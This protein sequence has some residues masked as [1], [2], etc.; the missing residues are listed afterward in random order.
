V[1]KNSGRRSTLFLRQEDIREA[2]RAIGVEPAALQA[3]A[4]VEASGTGFLPDGR[5]KILFEGHIMW[6]EL[7][8]RGLDPERFS[9]LYPSI[10]YRRWTRKHY[11]G[12][13]GEYARYEA[14]LKI[15][16]EAAIASTSWGAFQIMGFNYKAA[17][18]EDLRSFRHAMQSSVL[19]HLM[20]ICWWMQSNSLV[21]RLQAKD[22]EGFARG[23]N[24]PGF[25]VNR[26]DEKLAAAYAR[27][28]R[29]GYNQK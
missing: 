11:I 29:Q 6:R 12:D 26:Y 15:D 5:P 22:W 19:A 20:A 2:A 8:K 18:F 1:D 9:R 24:G 13:A 7:R 10:V 16:E 27:R 21:R 3:V 4:D 23:Y 17:G 25:K 14:A 28:V